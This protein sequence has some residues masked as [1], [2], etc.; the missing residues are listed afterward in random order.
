MVRG[1]RW[2]T[3]GAVLVVRI[4]PWKRIFC[5]VHLFRVP[6]SWTGSVQTKPSMTLI[7]GNRCIKRKRYFL[8]PWSKRLKE[9]ALALS[10]IERGERL[11]GWP[12]DTLHNALS[13]LT[14]KRMWIDFALSLW[15]SLAH[16]SIIILLMNYPFS[17]LLASPSLPL[18]GLNFYIKKSPIRTSYHWLTN[19]C[20]IF[21]FQKSGS[22]YYLS[23]DDTNIRCSGRENRQ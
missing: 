22:R 19:N 14:V 17:W 6:H 13:Q 20:M 3:R 7:R 2:N 12:A 11:D 10:N 9:C 1:T 18:P 4:I 21:L 5:N 8:K 15:S 16:Y 23:K